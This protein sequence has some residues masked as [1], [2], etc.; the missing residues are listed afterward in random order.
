MCRRRGMGELHDPGCDLD[1]D[2]LCGG[3]VLVRVVCADGPVLV[4]HTRE[5][6]RR[7]VGPVDMDGARVLDGDESPPLG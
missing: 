7:L 4:P 5:E 6:Y 1:E 3:R 2:C